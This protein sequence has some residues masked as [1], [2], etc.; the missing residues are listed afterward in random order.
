MLELSEKHLLRARRVHDARHAA[1]AI[2]AGITTVYTYDAGDW[3]SFE[4]DG[5]SIA[6][7]TTTLALLRRS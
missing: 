7:P 5:L 3:E 2:I 1:A 6:G 4:D